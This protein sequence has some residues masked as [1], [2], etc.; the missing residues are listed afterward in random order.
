M[1]N[2]ALVIGG[3]VGGCVAALEL[4]KL[5]FDVT[6]AESASELGGGVRTRL[7]SGHPFT[8]GPRH[9][10]TQSSKAFDYL[11]SIVPLRLCADHEFWSFVEQDGAFYNYPIHEDDIPKMPEAPQIYR[12]LQDAES[13]LRYQE[14][15]LD[16]DADVGDINN[17]RDF[18]LKSV[19]PTLYDKFIKSYTRKMWMIQDESQIDDF[20]WSPKGVAIKSGSRA[21]WDT[22]ISAYPQAPDG[23]NKL[24]EKAMNVGKVLF[25]SDVKVLDPQKNIV[26]IRGERRTYDVIVNSSPLD[27]SFTDT[28]PGKLKYIGRDIEFVVLP[29]KY[30]L[31][32]NVY[33]CYYT[34]REKYTRMVEYKKFTRHESDHTLVSLEYPS[35][36]GL[37]YPFPSLAYQQIHQLYLEMCGDRFFNIG[38]LALFNYRFDIDDAIL[39]ALAAKESLL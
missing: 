36:N 3:G 2:K 30:A 1:T 28:S 27:R 32:P 14:Y 24:F 18:W 23:Y 33:F 11:N 17:Y 29:I 38:R 20:T 15:R 19:G 4:A 39:Q 25:N 5:K 8:F 26:E 13:R 37:Y 21:G 22:A 10:L 16:K 31:P 12:E 34:G 7:I 6:I 35:T 9:F